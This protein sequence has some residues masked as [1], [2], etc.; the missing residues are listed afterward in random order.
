MFTE[1]ID[2]GYACLRRGDPEAALNRFQKA[3]AAEPQR[4]QAHFGMAMAYL[5]QQS[6]EGALRALETALDLDPHYVPARAYLG[7][8]LFKRYDLDGAQEALEQ[9]IQDEPTN[10]LAH[11]KYAE[12]YY[13]LGFYHRT[14]ELLEQGL[15]KPHGANEHIVQM[16][17]TFLTEARQ[18][19]KGIILREPPDPRR[20]LHIFD[21]LRPA[22][23]RRKQAEAR[24]KL[25]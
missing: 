20:L 10:L 17:R 25:R 21:R 3:A 4:P 23:A 1:L 5:D 24:G 19:R 2:E 12:Y 7:I 16:A 11:I 8:E 6:N 9:A 15:G 13:R 14:V 18:K 22:L